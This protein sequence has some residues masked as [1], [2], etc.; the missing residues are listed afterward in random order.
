MLMLLLLTQV[1]VLFACGKIEEP[2]LAGDHGVAPSSVLV[3]VCVFAYGFSTTMTPFEARLGRTPAGLCAADNR[4]KNSSV[5]VF[6]FVFLTSSS[7]SSS[8]A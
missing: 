7:S 5:L 3:T 1:S 2:V 8:S 6:L 4:I